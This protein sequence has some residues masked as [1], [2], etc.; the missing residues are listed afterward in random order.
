MIFLLEKL[1]FGRREE[2][3]TWERCIGVQFQLLRPWI[4]L[5]KCPTSSLSV[6]NKYTVVQMWVR[7]T[8]CCELN[9]A[10]VGSVNDLSKEFCLI[11]CAYWIINFKSDSVTCCS[12]FERLNHFQHIASFSKSGAVVA[13]KLV[14]SVV[15]L[16]DNDKP[17]VELGIQS[18]SPRLCS[19]H[20]FSRGD[21]T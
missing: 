4:E 21:T 15:V 5:P 6:W 3:E 12:V 18:S 8:V 10:F 7:Q 1:H 19:L 17:G 16:F 14:E 11:S 9:T 2:W 13:L 20:W